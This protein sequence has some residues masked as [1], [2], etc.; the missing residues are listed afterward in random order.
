VRAA[1]TE[2]AF[3]SA[4]GSPARSVAI[5]PGADVRADGRPSSTLA[6]RLE[7]ALDLYRAH[8]VK[9]ILVSGNDSA[10]S[11][12]VTAMRRWLAE[13]GVPAADVWVD[14]RGTRTRETMLNAAARFD[15]ADAVVCTQAPYVSRAVFLA[16]SAGIDAVG[17]GAPSPVSRSPRWLGV[18]ALKTTLAVVE[19]YLGRGPA[20]RDASQTVVAAR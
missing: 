13:R 5:V 20:A 19:S 12:E 4:S 16:R 11:P 15:V 8:R 6:Q 7:I 2:R 1:A 9:A 3:S 10:G 17:V 18:E 14:A